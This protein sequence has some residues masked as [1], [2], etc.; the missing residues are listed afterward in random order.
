MSLTALL[1]WL[2]LVTLLAMMF[3]AKVRAGHHATPRPAGD[4]GRLGPAAAGS[5]LRYADNCLGIILDLFALG[6]RRAA[7]ARL[8]ARLV[9]EE[10]RR[11]SVAQNHWSRAGTYRTVVVRSRAP[12]AG[13]IVANGHRS[14]TT[15][16]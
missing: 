15:R 13:R 12:R 9:D 14:R 11:C 6:R 16:T 10:N 2:P 5:A 1:R 8:V 3:A 7:V 4:F